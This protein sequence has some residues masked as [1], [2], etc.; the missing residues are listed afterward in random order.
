MPEII[1]KKIRRCDRSENDIDICYDTFGDAAKPPLVLIMGLGGQMVVWADDFC[2]KLAAHFHVIRF[3]NRD[4]GLSSK[5]ENKPAPS[6]VSHALPWWLHWYKTPE[7]YTLNCMALDVWALV[8]RVIGAG[9]K[10]HLMGVSMGGMIAQCAT[11]LEPSRVLSLISFM[12]TTNARDLPEPAWWVKFRMMSRPKTQELDDRVAF[13]LGM[14]RDVLGYDTEVDLEPHRELS[15]RIVQRSNYVKGYFRHL[16]AIQRA[17]PRDEL[18][19]SLGERTPPTLV[20]HGRKD[21]LVPLKHG[22]R[23]AEVIHGAKLVVFEDMG[24]VF[25]RRHYDDIIAEIRIIAKL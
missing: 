14:I 8:D 17:M 22:Q 3:D 24:H 19:R 6:I 21:V 2:E 1:A 11:L 16:A 25:E 5:I 20:L 12:S 13:R 7:P 9:A 18:F 15:V 23:T 10:V 4:V